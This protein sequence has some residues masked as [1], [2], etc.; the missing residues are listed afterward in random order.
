MEKIKNIIKNLI[1]DPRVKA[2]TEIAVTGV[3]TVSG[4]INPIAPFVIEA[5]RTVASC[6]DEI[7]VDRMLKGF[8]N[9]KN[10]EMKLNELYNFVKDSDERAF[11]VSNLF[12]QTLLTQSPKV[13]CIYG[14]ILSEL[15]EN[16]EILDYDQLI[17][18]NA[19]QTAT[20][21]E[22]KYFREIVKDYI[23]DDRYINENKINDSGILSYRMTLE[24]CKNNRIFDITSYKQSGGFDLIGEFYEVNSRSKKL[25][26]Y[27]DK[28]RQILNYEENN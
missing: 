10:I 6:A 20:D 28:A 9:G 14:I 18:F 12:R 27:I 16:D 26:E 15:Q 13:C 2:G 7:K 22:I 3:S 5:Y 21:Y 24:W 17:I 19:L 11:L 23:D 4:M 25:A 1:E 8:A